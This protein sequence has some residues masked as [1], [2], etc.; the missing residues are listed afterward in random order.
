M[1][2]SRLSHTPL[3]C[4][5]TTR[6]PIFRT[7]SNSKCSL[8]SDLVLCTWRQYIIASCELWYEFELFSYFVVLLFKGC[9][10]FINITVL[11]YWSL[12]S[13]SAHS[14][15]YAIKTQKLNYTPASLQ[16]IDVDLIWWWSALLMSSYI[17]EMIVYQENCD[18][19]NEGWQ[20]DRYEW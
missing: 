15:H 9:Y 3:P 18:A 2:P 16:F 10:C 12:K 11:C 13:P 14:L 4:L 1:R 8:L 7:T 20:S 17:Y 5:Q 19:I 6:C